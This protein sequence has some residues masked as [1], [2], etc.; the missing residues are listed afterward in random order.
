MTAESGTRDAESGNDNGLRIHHKEHKV[1]KEGRFFYFFVVLGVLCAFVSF[2]I[3]QFYLFC[4]LLYGYFN[5][6]NN[7]PLGCYGYSKVGGGQRSIARQQVRVRGVCRLR[8][9]P[10]A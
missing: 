8:V 2:V 9:N 10:G 5:H 4:V 1:H 6:R 3:K 7:G